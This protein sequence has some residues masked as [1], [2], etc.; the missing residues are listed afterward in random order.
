MKTN[1]G[2]FAAKKYYTDDSR[3][4][5]VF[6]NMKNKLGCNDNAFLSCDNDTAVSSGDVLVVIPMSG[7]VQGRII[8]YCKNYKSIIMYAAYIEGNFDEDI[9]STLMYNN[10]APA[11]MD[12]LSVLNKE[13]SCVFIAHNESELKKY[14]KISDAY[15]HVKNAKLLLI[16][17]T[18]PW[19]ISASHDVKAYEKY[20]ITTEQIKQQEIMD[21]F[22]ETTESDAKSIIEHFTKVSPK[23]VE[24]NEND[25]VSAA[26]MA[27]AIN[28]TVKAHNA[29]C[30]AI[31]CFNLLKSGTNSCLGVSY[32]NDMTDRVISCEGDMD[33]AVTMLI[34]KR[35]SDTK[36]WMANPGLHPDGIINFSHCTSC[37]NVFGNNSL[38]Y[39]LRN[40]H[41][42]SIGVSLQV[43]YPLNQRV[44]ACRISAKYNTMS[45][46]CGTTIE[47]KYEN[48]CRTQVYVKFDDYNKYIN[49]VLGCHQVFAFEDISENVKILGEK[50]GFKIV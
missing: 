18:E 9:S 21:R 24:P 41:E 6:E 31:S 10:S 42:S 43:D 3:L 25:I 12:C 27:Y 23:C 15:C 22:N 39:T 26:R 33:S 1:Y 40:H 5:S 38:N 44:T 30:I 32:I 20:G 8:E 11:L 13:H 48:A 49:N 29:D 4:S 50:L 28:E 19:V 14:I 47:G 17:D 34:M 7:A 46:N 35:L 16:G 2:F 37:I 36:L 45:I